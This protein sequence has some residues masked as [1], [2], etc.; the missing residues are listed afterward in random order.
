MDLLRA[1]CASMGR[2]S[3]GLVGRGRHVFGAVMIAVGVIWGMASTAEATLVPEP[4]QLYIPYLQTEPLGLT[5]THW[6]GRPAS[7]ING[8]FYVRLGEGAVQTREVQL[9]D[10]VDLYSTWSPDGQYLLIVNALDGEH[11]LTRLDPDGSN[12]QVIYE[13]PRACQSP[14]WSPGS[15]RIAFSMSGEEPFAADIYL[16]DPDGEN[17]RQFTTD[18]RDNYAPAWSPDGTL[19]AFDSTDEERSETVIY[20]A[21]LDGDVLHTLAGPGG[22]SSHPTWSPDGERIAFGDYDAALVF[23]L[24]MID[25]HGA[26]LTTITTAADLGQ[27]GVSSPVWSPDGRYIAFRT[28]SLPWSTSIAIIKP[29]GVGFQVVAGAGTDPAW[30]P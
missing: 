21:N 29:N 26:N 28:W 4:S 10:E 27:S 11:R 20:V 14:A 12:R 16:I 25:W 30:K 6:V 7:R 5:Y 8:L 17:L 22:N 3:T 9:T 19:L 15:D 23:T 18:N 2:A 13:C 24:Y 1:V